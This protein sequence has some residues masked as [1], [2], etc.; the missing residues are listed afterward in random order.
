MS[1]Y[2]TFDFI[3]ILLAIFVMV[4]VIFVLKEKYKNGSIGYLN[5]IGAVIMLIAGIGGLIIGMYGIYNSI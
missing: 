3:I 4:D 5:I 2:N 1:N